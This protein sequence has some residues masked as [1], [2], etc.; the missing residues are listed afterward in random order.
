MISSSGSVGAYI[1]IRRP[2]PYQSVDHTFRAK[3]TSNVFE[4]AM[5]YK[6][7]DSSGETVRSGQI[8]ATSGSGTPGTFNKRIRVP[9]DAPAGAYKLVVYNT[10]PKDGSVQCRDAVKILVH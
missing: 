4:A 10:S 2:T 6:L 8:R 7:K 9:E 3:G 1:D 5:L